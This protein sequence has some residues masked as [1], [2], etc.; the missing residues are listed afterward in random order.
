MKSALK[1]MLNRMRLAY[2]IENQCLMITTPDKTSGRLERRTFPIGDLVVVVPDHPLPDVF[3]IQRAIERSMSYQGVYGSQYM[4]QPGYALSPGQ[5]VSSHSN[6]LGGAFGEQNVGAKQWQGGPKGTSA[7]DNS[8]QAMAEVLMELIQNTVAKN[9]WESMGGNGNIQYF[10]FGMALV[11]NQP[12]EVQEEVALLLATLR[13]LQDLQVSVELRAV[14]VSE[15]FF[16]RIGVDFDMNIR[17]PTS[18]REPDLVA[19]NFV[20]APFINRTGAGLGGLISG[21]TSAGTLTPDLNIPIRNSTFN[22]TT[23]QFG[24]YQPEAGLTLGLAF[25]SD[26]QVFMFLEAVQGDRLAHIMQAPKLTVFNGQ[27]AT[28]SGLM[29]R[30]TV[31]GLIPA[32]LGNGQM[33]MIPLINQ[34]PFGLAMQIQPVVSPDRRFIRLN[35]TPQLVAGVQDPAGAIVIAVPG[36]TGA[37]FDG[38]GAQPFFASNPLSVQINP[39]GAD[40]QIAN[41]TVNVPDGGTVL[42]GGFK[43]LAEERTEYGPPVLS[44]IPYISRLFRN[45]GWS[46]DGSTLIYLVT[47]RIIMV[48]EE[49]QIFLGNLT[50]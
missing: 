6:G 44:K 9:S 23:P 28:I 30:P 1:L 18:R 29:L 5:P 42:L 34:M 40:L 31:Q 24:G 25:L 4:A 19:G 32:A 50:R 26:I 3:N 27:I 35:V 45:V 21:L 38:G 15:T 12:T 16:E 10:P 2:T 13:K 36:S 41:T 39:A 46:R 48:E 17:T 37:T 14:L 43:F 22:F 20:P 47:A 49:E 11:I 7:K 8:K 33:F